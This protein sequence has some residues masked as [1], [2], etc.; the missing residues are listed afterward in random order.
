M[1]DTRWCSYH[2]AAALKI[3]V[4][5]ADRTM[6]LSDAWSLLRRAASN[7][8]QDTGWGSIAGQWHLRLLSH[9]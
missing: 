9:R 8:Q 5:I 3:A 7:R 4:L 6:L 2:S 1:Q